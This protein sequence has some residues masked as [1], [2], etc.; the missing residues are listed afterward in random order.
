MSGVPSTQKRERSGIQGTIEMSR[1]DVNEQRDISA[2][3]SM[4][5]EAGSDDGASSDDDG[6]VALLNP[7]R[8]SRGRELEKEGSGSTWSQVKDIVIE[9]HC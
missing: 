8:Q 3:M 7:E 6:D 9:V 1:L 5:D 4:T 2:S